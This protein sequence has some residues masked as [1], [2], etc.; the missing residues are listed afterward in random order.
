MMT[1]SRGYVTT[2]WWWSE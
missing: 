2:S 1:D